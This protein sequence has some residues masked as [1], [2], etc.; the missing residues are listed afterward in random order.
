L[1]DFIIF[2]LS[3]IG[4]TFIITQFYIFKNIREYISKHSKFYGKLFQCTAC[5][6]FW[7]GCLIKTLLLI[8][9]HQ[10]ILFSLIIILIYGFI[11]SFTSFLTYIII[12]PL[13]DKHG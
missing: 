7:C 10:F 11:G 13:M 8:Y 1:I 12:K 2:I 5:M 6:G 3:T 4:L 9:Y